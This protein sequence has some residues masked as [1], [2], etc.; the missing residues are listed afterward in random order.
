VPRKLVLLNKQTRSPVSLPATLFFISWISCLLLLRPAYCR[1]PTAPASCPLCL[2][3]F[4]SCAKPF[5]CP[6]VPWALN[7]KRKFSFKAQ[8]LSFSPSFSL[9]SAA[10]T[11]TR[12]HFNGFSTHISPKEVLTMSTHSYTRLWTHQA[13]PLGKYAWGG[14]AFLVSHSDVARAA[15]AL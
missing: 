12:N 7:I 14:G 3:P 5:P 2:E 1:L 6:R 15:R 4:A 13:R 9:V 10:P 8:P 11:S